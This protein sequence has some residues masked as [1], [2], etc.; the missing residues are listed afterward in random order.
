MLPS[1]HML[2]GLQRSSQPAQSISAVQSAPYLPSVLFQEAHLS[3]RSVQSWQ[4]LQQRL[5]RSKLTALK[6]VTLKRY[7]SPLCKGNTHWKPTQ[8]RAIAVG[9]QGVQILHPLP[10]LHCIMGE[11]MMSALT[12]YVSLDGLC[13]N[14]QL[15]LSTSCGVC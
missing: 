8:K 4:Q 13:Q 14:M 2:A 3:Y 10:Y 7:V 5:G 1:A 15:Q 6:A 9:H 12:A 11:L